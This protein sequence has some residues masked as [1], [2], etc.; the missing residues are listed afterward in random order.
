MKFNL[1]V[2]L[3][4]SIQVNATEIEYQGKINIAQ[5]EAKTVRHSWCIF[6]DGDSK[7]DTQE[8][9][10]SG[11][12]NQGSSTETFSYRGV[13]YLKRK[14]EWVNTE[15][16]NGMILKFVADDANF[17]GSQ[18]YDKKLCTYK[19]WK[20]QS[21]SAETILK[22]KAAFILPKNVWAIKITSVSNATN[23][24]VSI[25]LSNNDYVVKD[26]KE[27][28]EKKSLTQFGGNESGR[29]YLVNP[30]S[31]DDDNFLYLD[32][33]YQSKTLNANS[34]DL[35]FKIEFIAAEQCLSDLS[36][37]SINDLLEKN[38]KANKIESALTNVA[39]ML[40]PHYVQHSLGLIQFNGL[41]DIFK[42][43]SSVEKNI[44][45]QM[46][47]QSTSF[48]RETHE[49]LLSMLDRVRFYYAYE[50]LKEAM[51]IFLYQ[52]DFQGN[53]IDGITYLEVLKRRGLLY[54]YEVFDNLS[55][56]ISKIK[57]R[58][59]PF[60]SLT[61]TEAIKLDVFL[62]TIL[63]VE[64]R[65]L[66]KTHSLIYRP[67]N[68]N[69]YAFNNLEK[70]IKNILQQSEVLNQTSSTVFQ[71]K[72]LTL[73][74]LAKIDDELKNMSEALRHYSLQIEQIKLGSTDNSV[75]SVLE[76]RK[77]ILNQ[78]EL[79]Y[80]VNIESLIEDLNLYFIKHF[81][82]PQFKNIKV[83]CKNY[84]N[85]FEFMKDFKTFILEIE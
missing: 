84:S 45:N 82:D 31:S 38:V 47:P 23:G 71:S 24:V 32:F 2:F 73:E 14:V 60:I 33:R 65:N 69:S 51:A 54:L 1:F 61:D 16:K 85:P 39:C 57:S 64:F 53:K 20:G 44:I 40:N 15:S 49:V 63:P 28:L 48:E 70:A 27:I 72:E 50:I 13:N 76:N 79:I 55:E 56:T 59:G 21:T 29:Y 8:I 18:E 19:T 34:L 43:L 77:K 75:A 25:E 3:I 41:D 80:Q 5:Y 9:S 74:Q 81:E 67:E 22:G 10:S 7:A 78:I 4:F 58:P 68:L 62:N 6:S 66:N 36:G 12:G 52:V 26:G 11:N 30:S 83:G 42:Q 46:S 35:D 17:H 37:L